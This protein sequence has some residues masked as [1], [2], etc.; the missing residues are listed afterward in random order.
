MI[1]LL[2]TPLEVYTSSSKPSSNDSNEIAAIEYIAG[3]FIKKM[4]KYTSENS[5]VTA[6]NN[7][8]QYLLFHLLEDID[9]S[10]E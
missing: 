5:Q 2:Y 4:I 6:D 10:C 9:S 8:Y 3:Y 1:G 7:K